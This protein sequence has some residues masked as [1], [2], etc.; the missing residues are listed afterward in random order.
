MHSCV[1]H[2]PM[3]VCA[4]YDF[5]AL[6]GPLYGVT[7]ATTV[8]FFKDDASV[9]NVAPETDQLNDADTACAALAQYIKVLPSRNSVHCVLIS[10]GYPVLFFIPRQHVLKHSVCVCVEGEGAQPSSTKYSSSAATLLSH[11]LNTTLRPGSN[12][13]HPMLHPILVRSC[14]HISVLH[15]SNS[16]AVVCA[17]LCCMPPILV[18]SCVHISVLHASNSSAVVCACL[19]CMRISAL[20]VGRSTL[21]NNSGELRGNGSTMVARL[22]TRK[23]GH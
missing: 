14:V 5:S 15:A 3:Q 2:V 7:S 18:R 10:C 23:C 12:S 20:N 17:C 8:G 9:A 16:S 11:C 19:C 6:L 1:W 4:L 21:P 13:N 22:S